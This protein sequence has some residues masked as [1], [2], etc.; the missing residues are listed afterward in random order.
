MPSP[1]YA[2]SPLKCVT[3]GPAS[4]LVHFVACLIVANQAA[5]FIHRFV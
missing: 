1:D 5:N 4:K 2:A 3:N